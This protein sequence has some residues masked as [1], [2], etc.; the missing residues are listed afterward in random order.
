MFSAFKSHSSRDVSRFSNLGILWTPSWKIWGSIAKFWGSR[1]FST[2]SRSIASLLLLQ[3][4]FRFLFCTIWS[5]ISPLEYLT[6]LPW[7]RV[8]YEMVNSQW[9]ANGLN[10]KIK[11]L[12]GPPSPY[13]HCVPWNNFQYVKK[14][15]AKAEIHPIRLLWQAMRISIT[16]TNGRKVYW[17]NLGL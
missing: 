16:K 7:G 15:S 1:I 5:L 6:I 9:G 3:Y 14:I 17:L 10:V 11:F 12:Q 4:P 2:C 13:R 8:A